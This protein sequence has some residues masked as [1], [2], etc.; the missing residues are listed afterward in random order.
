MPIAALFQSLLGLSAAL[1]TALAAVI[2][3]KGQGAT[4]ASYLQKIQYGSLF[5]KLFYLVQIR[6]GIYQLMRQPEVQNALAD[7]GINP[8]QAES[9]TTLALDNVAKMN[10]PVIYYPTFL[11]DVECEGYYAERNFAY[12]AGAISYAEYLAAYS[13]YVSEYNRIAGGQPAPT[14]PIIPAP[15]ALPPVLPTYATIELLNIWW[16]GI[17]YNFVN[18][19]ISSDDYARAYAHYVI[20]YHDITLAGAVVVP[21]SGTTQGTTTVNVA[22]P[23]VNVS[24]LI[25]VNVPPLPIQIS[26]APVDGGAIG[27]PIA[28]SITN[29]SDAFVRSNEDFAKTL[30]AV[31]PLVGTAAITGI[32]SQASK[33]GHD[34][35][36]GQRSCWGNTATDLLMRLGQAAIPLGAVMAVEGFSPLR[37]AM[38]GVVG[39]IF[40]DILSA[41]ALQKP[42][43]PEDAPDV[44]AALL[45]KAAKFGMEAHLISVA[46]E[47]MTPLKTLGIGQLA[48]ML[49][50][51][52]GFAKIGGAMMGAIET[53]GLARPFGFYIN[54]KT[55]TNRPNA[56][57]LGA[58]AS[59][60]EIKIDEY[61]D[62][63]LYQ[64]FP[65][66][67]SEKMFGLGFR[68]LAPRQLQ[69]MAEAGLADDAFFDRE[70][71]HG[72]LR[73]E[74]IPLVKE[75]FRLAGIGEL[76]PMGQAVAIKRYREGISNLGEL[77]LELDSL[78]FRGLKLEMAL[79][80]A[81]LE[82]N[83]ELILDQIALAKQSFLAG[84][85][86]A[87]DL[88][89]ELWAIGIEKE[90]AALITADAVKRFKAP[91]LADRLPRLTE[92]LAQTYIDNVER[93]YAVSSAVK[94]QLAALKYTL[95]EADTALKTA[96]EKFRQKS[97]EDRISILEEKFQDKEITLEE[98]KYQLL[99]IPISVEL[100]AHKAELARLRAQPTP[101][102]LLPDDIPLLTT[103]Q[104]L[105]AFDANVISEISLRAELAERLYQ[106]GDIDIMVAVQKSKV[107][108]PT[109]AAKKLVSETQLKAFLA[110]GLMSAQEFYDELIRR[111]YAAVDADRITELELIKL[112]AR[113]KV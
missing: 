67:W 2:A 44:A 74:T 26:V 109:A 30:G 95:A 86:D 32:L 51:M 77:S 40:D 11:T 87:T 107:A 97:T 75:M 7:Q 105:A 27:Q 28:D 89:A 102:A 57:Q 66:S 69:M 36:T 78:G 76:K 108:A 103:S 84:D 12:Q 25:S 43:L 65:K 48:A 111:G 46:A 5:E 24:P 93:G 41:P 19:Y 70:L 56:G 59:N 55:L 1:A 104:L 58:L 110:A 62:E 72:G 112:E 100:A 49:G 39:R 38:E 101:K 113:L 9:Q 68:A 61:Q 54:S 47:I 85:I 33:F 98:L 82:K 13:W 34:V 8:V 71:R 17:E 60:Y 18:N 88:D 73:E 91:K 23:T 106:P 15:S 14:L 45:L 21:P 6:L 35:A 37:N 99:S 10:K 42:I 16:S 4:F 79:K 81:Q 22:A 31:L 53:Q 80:S 29:L 20:L 3:L 63:M 64:G 92:A 94:P 52:A 90:K 50:D 83:T 96:E